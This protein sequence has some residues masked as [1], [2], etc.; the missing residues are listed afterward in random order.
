MNA[1]R[2]EGGARRPSEYP[3]NRPAWPPNSDNCGVRVSV[4]T[5]HKLFQRP[6]P[7]PANR[8]PVHG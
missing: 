3:E 8:F 6:R 7:A 4:P 2:E 5:I 1:D